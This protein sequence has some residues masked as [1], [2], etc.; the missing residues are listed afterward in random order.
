MPTLKRIHKA[1]PYNVEFGSVGYE[2]SFAQEE[3]GIPPCT[4]EEESRDALAYMAYRTA[5][6]THELA[7]AELLITTE[8][9]LRV[10]QIMKNT[11]GGKLT[12]VEARIKGAVNAT[13]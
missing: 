1:K 4:N 9:S 6:A 11:L 5:I 7:I 12:R 3:L 8:E 13:L 2:V 10:L